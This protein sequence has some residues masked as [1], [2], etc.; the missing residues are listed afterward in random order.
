MVLGE[1]RARG[2]DTVCA[3]PRKGKPGIDPPARFTLGELPPAEHTGGR[4]CA[5]SS[6]PVDRRP[7]DKVIGVSAPFPAR[8]ESEPP[9]GIVVVDDAKECVINLTP[10]MSHRL[11]TQYSA[12]SAR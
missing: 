2:V 7:A 11:V 8:R 1:A 10:A 4:P 6:E 12:G 9:L 5:K 3:V